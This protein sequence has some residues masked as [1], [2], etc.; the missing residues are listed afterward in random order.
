MKPESAVR[1]LNRRIKEI[2]EY[3]G[4]SSIEYAE[5]RST[6]YDVFGY[7][8]EHVLLPGKKGKPFVSVSRSKS[9]LSNDFYKEKIVEAWEEVRLLGT[10]KQLAEPYLEAG[11]NYRDI[12]IRERIRVESKTE[13]Y[14]NFVDKDYYE[15]WQEEIDKPEEW[16][17]DE[18]YAQNLSE[19]GEMFYETGNKEQKWE[20]IRQRFIDMQ[21]SK[22]QKDE[23]KA[24]DNNEK[25]HDAG[26]N[27]Y[28]MEV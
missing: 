9:L 16:L 1:A 20:R 12:D 3:F 21:I 28:R 25:P 7:A 10:V 18:E 26:S 23:E 6:L 13:Y 5:V 19:I 15:Q 17:E 27:D 8:T 4:K 2:G 11:E 22:A 14:E 24:V